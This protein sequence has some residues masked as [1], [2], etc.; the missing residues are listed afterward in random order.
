MSSM[1]LLLTGAS[2]V[3]KSTV[4][5]LLEPELSSRVRCAELSNL[6]PI[7]PHP[8]LAWRHEATESAVRHALDAQTRGLGFLLAGDPV[9][10]GEVIA[11]P[12]ADRLDGFAACLLDCRADV[13]RR[14]LIG[15]GD[16]PAT[17]RDHEAFADWIR[18][19][20]RD[21][22]HR[23]EVITTTGWAAMR[24]D[25]WR[26]IRAGDPCWRFGEIDTTELSPRQVAAEAL[27]WC[28]RA[29]DGHC[30]NVR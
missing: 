26:G 1:F 6:V 28:R 7:P 30:E 4:R 17:L 10:P 22:Q 9:V 13:Q 25:R 11:A 5:A 21:P 12:S 8:D 19:H 15:R 29:L 18:G 23:P 3:G 27:D 16:S 14:R 2:G 20:V 24:W